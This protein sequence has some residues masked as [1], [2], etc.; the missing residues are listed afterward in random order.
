MMIKLKIFML[1][2]P[3]LQIQPY[4]GLQQIDMKNYQEYNTTIL[5]NQNAMTDIKATIKT[6][7]GEIRLEL[8][9]D[10]AP[11]TVANFVNL[12]LR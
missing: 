9:S 1:R 4:Q 11:H 8:H 5:L 10:K 6:T 2:H 12:A 7:K 3:I